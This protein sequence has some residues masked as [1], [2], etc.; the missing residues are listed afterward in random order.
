LRE[1][2]PLVRDVVLATRFLLTASL[3]LQC[4]FTVRSYDK[5]EHSLELKKYIRILAE[6]GLETESQFAWKF[7]NQSRNGE[8]Q[9]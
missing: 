6:K 3:S 5:E 2:Y 1:T 9:Q 4:L 8:C 7:N